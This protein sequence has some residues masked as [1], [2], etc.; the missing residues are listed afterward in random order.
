VL[1]GLA[2]LFQAGV[3]GDVLFNLFQYT[4]NCT[5][6]A[7]IG[8]KSLRQYFMGKCL[9]SCLTHLSYNSPP[10]EDQCGDCNDIFALCFTAS[11]CSL[12]EMSFVVLC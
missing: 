12:K 6:Y 3:C 5:L 1:S 7:L 11:F 10:N 8:S 9:F 4:I 2:G